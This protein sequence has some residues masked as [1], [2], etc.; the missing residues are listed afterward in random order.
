MRKRINKYLIVFYI[1]SI[2]LLIYSGYLIVDWFIDNNQNKTAKNY[3]IKISDIK[4]IDKNKP[5]PVITNNTKQIKTT[6]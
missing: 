6:N 5:N 4:V 1:A 3:T 2:I